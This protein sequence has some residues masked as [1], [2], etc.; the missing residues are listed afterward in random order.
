MNLGLD[1]AGKYFLGPHWSDFRTVMGPILSKFPDL[2]LEGTPE[3]RTAAEK[4]IATL[5]SDTH[6]KQLIEKHLEKIGATTSNLWIRLDAVETALAY[7]ERRISAIENALKTSVPISVSA[8]EPQY[9]RTSFKQI[10]YKFITEAGSGAFASLKGPCIESALSGCVMHES[11]IFPP[12]AR[13]CYISKS[14][15]WTFAKCEFFNAKV[16]Y[17]FEKPKAEVSSA[18]DLFRKGKLKNIE[19]FTPTR[20][21]ALLT[22]VEVVKKVDQHIPPHWEKVFPTHWGVDGES[23]ALEKLLSTARG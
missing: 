4:A 12:G 2:L 5:Q 3:S 11:T 23:R 18:A 10:M 8:T 20:E 6:F 17:L 15:D 9:D 1:K 19:I 13:E 21:E 16:V 22:F 7:H 14:Y